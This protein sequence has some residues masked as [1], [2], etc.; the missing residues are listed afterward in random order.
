MTLQEEM[1][2]L[3]ENPLPITVTDMLLPSRIYEVDQDIASLRKKLQEAEF[4]RNDLIDRA[5]DLKILEDEHARIEFKERQIRT[6]DPGIF[7]QSFPEEFEMI[8]EQQRKELVK[9]AT[10]VGEVIPLGLADKLAGKDRVTAICLI[11]IERTPY[12]VRK[13]P[14]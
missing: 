2:S 1:R 5:L 9:K 14:T 10:A 12:V 11:D 13:V 6:L 7:K 3:R 4:L 8:C